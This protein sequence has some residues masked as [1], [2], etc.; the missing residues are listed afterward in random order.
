MTIIGATG[1][2]PPMQTGIP[3]ATGGIPGM[4]GGIPGMGGGIPG[5]G[6]G[7]PGMTGGGM[8]GGMGGPGIPALTPQTAQL[9]SGL[10][11]DPGMILAQSN[12]NIY[13]MQQAPGTAPTYLATDFQQ[14]PGGVQELL[15]MGNMEAIQGYYELQQQAYQNYMQTGVYGVD[16]FVAANS[17]AQTLTAADTQVQGL[18]KTVTASS[19][20]MLGALQD[21][22]KQTTPASDAG[23]GGAPP[24]GGLGM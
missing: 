23:G 8:L 19:K 16:P 9:Y 6:G 2:V 1:G 24:G 22:V 10:G 17:Y 5:M 13:A 20:S 4:T 15:G 14:A 3:G 11:L 7:I 18:A 21:A 12:P